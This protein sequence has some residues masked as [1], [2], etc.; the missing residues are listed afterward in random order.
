MFKQK[1]VAWQD[2]PRLREIT[3]VLAKY[4]LGGLFQRLKLP[5]RRER[6]DS[7]LAQTK[8]LS[9]PRRFRM[10]FE[11]LGPTYVKLGQIISTRIDIFPPEWIQEFSQLQNNVKPVGAEEI[12]A[13]LEASYGRKI[14]EV[15]K[16]FDPVPVGSASIAQVHRAI[17]FTG[18]VVAVKVKRPNVDDKVR[19]DI[20]I[21]TRLVSLIESEMPEVRR[22]QPKQMFLYFTKSLRL[23]LDLRNEAQYLKRF[24]RDFKDSQD[25]HIP[26]IYE[27]LSNEQVLVQEFIS[28]CLLKDI[29]SLQL[30]T[31]QKKLI[32]TRLADAILRMVLVNGIFHADPHP[33]NIFINEQGNLTL[34]D[35]GLVGRLN[36]KRQEEITGLIQALIEHD[37]LSMQ[38]ILSNWTQ[39]D[40]LLDEGRLGQDVM[41]IM[42]NY[43][44]VSLKHLC[45]SE[46]INDIVTV[47]REHQLVLPPELV[48]LFKTLMMVESIVRGLD[49]DFELLEHTKPLVL[50]IFKQHHSISQLVKKSRIQA[51]LYKQLLQDLPTNALYLGKHLR[52]GRFSINLDMKRLEEFG[53]QIDHTANR[54]TMGIVTGSLIIGSSIVMSVQ[55]GPKIFGLPLFGF[56][57]YAIAFLNS[58][59]LIW[60]IWRSGKS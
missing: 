58:I 32:G 27:D 45:I 2:I 28:G 4:G 20:R 21:L 22:Y 39:L 14:T 33:G 59:W 11:E 26:R 57:V 54:L 25:I 40:E 49:E 1:R 51:R 7:D 24:G 17:L 47:I 44:H 60:S 43:E 50:N 13:L 36:S 41:D 9:L 31:E 52:N 42:L 6:S 23:D 12:V 30:G 55:A 38:M 29:D 18:E 46:V 34:I 53:A 37:E 8:L 3:A 56:V 48:M 19:A 10:A 15:F 35:F 16:E 5:G